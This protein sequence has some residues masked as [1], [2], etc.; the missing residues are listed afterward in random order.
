MK[1][2]THHLI[3]APK[4]CFNFQD[5][6][7]E[8]KI[9]ISGLSPVTT[10]RFQVFSVNG[11]SDVTGE[12]GDFVDITVTT[13]ASVM[14]ASVTNLRTTA[15]KASEITLTWDPPF[16]PDVDS[17]SGNHVE[18]YEV[19][20]CVF[21]CLTWYFILKITSIQLNARLLNYRQ[22]NIDLKE[23]DYSTNIIECTAFSEFTIM[24]QS[25]LL[26]HILVKVKYFGKKII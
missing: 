21:L 5:I 9:T 8:T 15:V 22:I 18:M 1:F 12:A 2:T 3:I 19:R 20:N 13:E 10:Y 25:R 26:D 14:S 11:V 23:H 24:W 7:N 6:F 17:D 16:T 4:I